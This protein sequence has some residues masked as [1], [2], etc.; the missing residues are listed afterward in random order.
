MSS[1]DFRVA[2]LGA[3]VVAGLLAK[4]VLLI[5]VSGSVTGSTVRSVRPLLAAKYR[6]SARV[7]IA[8]YSGALMALDAA[9]IWDL[10]TA[11]CDQSVPPLP[12]AFVVSPSMAGPMT[13]AALSAGISRGLLCVVKRDV[14]SALAWAASA[15]VP[16]Y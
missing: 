8:D 11:G 2:H 15:R 16:C 13:D 6:A 9:D 14:Q 7:V 3:S 4:G 1:V 12:A 5:T 10:M